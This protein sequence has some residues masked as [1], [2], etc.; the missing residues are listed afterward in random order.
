MLKN[1][2]NNLLF[3]IWILV[4]FPPISPILSVLGLEKKHSKASYELTEYTNYVT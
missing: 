4:S 1:I 2:D 3:Y